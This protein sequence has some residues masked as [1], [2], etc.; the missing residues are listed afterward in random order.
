ME[1]TGARAAALKVLNRVEGSDAYADIAL[2]TELRGMGAQEAAL[3]T[4]LAYG[5]LRWKLRLD[6]TIGLFS[7]IKTSKLEHRVLNALR[8][9]AYQLLFLSKIPASAAINESVELV[10][11]DRKKAGFVNAILRKIDSERERIK[12]PE[13]DPVKH[14]SIFWSHPEWMV[15]R[16]AARYGMEETIELC[17]AG[18]EVP[19]RTIR[20]NT[21]V[22]SRDGLIRELAS[23]GFDAAPSPFSSYGIEVRGGGPLGPKD[24][25]YYVQDEASQLIPLLLAP[26]PGEA[27]MDACS[28]P[29]GKATHMAEIMGNKGL[30][31]AL[32]KHEARLRPVNESASRLGVD[33]VRTFAADAA[34]PF[35]F[36]ERNSIDAILCDA[37]CS[38]LGVL[39]RTPDSKY[40]R[41]EEDIKNLSILQAAILDNLAGYLKGGGRLVYSTCTFEPEETDDIISGFLERHA[42]FQLEDA[43]AVLPE[44]CRE[45]VD[46]KG[47]LRTFPHRHRMDG[48]FGARLKKA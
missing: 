42:D 10:K 46:A 15:R 3:S 29:G 1:R 22:I 38:G 13:D 35:G 27:V 5:V 6:F 21:L 25:R 7:S 33:I 24:N 23:E 45:L 30:I 19:P 16:W 36:V 44:A 48:F 32:D 11:P 14:T 34:E 31:Y 39:R 4:E 12:V 8:L 26:T 37:S 43:S 9:G 18:Q 20:A 28:A 47:V 41:K 40:R 17:K 2:D